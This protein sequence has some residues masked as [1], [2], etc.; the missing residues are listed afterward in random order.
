M[1]N[2]DEMTTPKKAGW[3]TDEWYH[4]GHH[5]DCP[6]CGEPWHDDYPV[7]GR[8]T[9]ERDEAQRAQA[10]LHGRYLRLEVERDEA[11][12]EV[13]R[14]RLDMRSMNA[15]HDRLFTLLRRVDRWMDEALP[16]GTHP[17][18]LCDDIAAVLEKK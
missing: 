15:E 11:R 1:S 17:H 7:P 6:E 16:T 3:P 8:L 18:Q 5:R 13:N 9:A 14:C 10:N 2:S 12:A 4:D